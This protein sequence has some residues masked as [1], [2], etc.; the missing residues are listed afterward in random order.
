MDTILSG[1]SVS[2]ILSK[3]VLSC[4]EDSHRFAIERK[5]KIVSLEHYLYHILEDDAIDQFFQSYF[6]LKAVDLQNMIFAE[7]H[8]IDNTADGDVIPQNAEIL[9]LFFISM[10]GGY[11]NLEKVYT[12]NKSSGEKVVFDKKINMFGFLSFIL[13]FLVDMKEEN[14]DL[15]IYQI[16]DDFFEGVF[17][18]Q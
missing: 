13:Y 9:D 15:K 16:M 8:Q 18:N 6:E 14:I 1:N 3:D 12:Y 2:K 17:D 11:R 5:H 7:L 4:I 10:I